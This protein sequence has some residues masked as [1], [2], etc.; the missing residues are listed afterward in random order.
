MREAV[1]R[2]TLRH[3]LARRLRAACVALGIG[4]ALAAPLA[5][6]SPALAQTKFPTAEEAAAALAKAAGAHD[7]AALRAILGP[8]SDRVVSSGDPVADRSAGDRFAQ[9]YAAKNSLAA[10][11]NGSKILTVGENDWPLPI[12]LVQAAGGWQFDISTAEDEI[13][14]R[15][16]GRN[17]LWTIRTLLAGVLA[18]KD[19]FD[20]AQRGTGTG[21]YAQRI[22]STPG[23]LDGLYWET[24]PGEAPSPLTPLV[25]Q[26]MDEGYPGAIA[27]NGQPVPYHGYFFRVLKAQG[28]HAPG[29][30]KDYVRKGEMTEGFA[31]L[32]WPARYDSSGV[33]S[34]LVGPDG[35]VYQ[36]DLGPGTARAAAGIT[37][38]DPDLSWV[39]VKLAD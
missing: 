28:P 20:R 24:D 9:A 14:D 26:A 27:P 33:V 12:P 10:G 22:L 37:R 32:A 18:E 23:K 4:L 19:Y 30:A 6:A 8:Q 5:G 16:I 21:F 36:K 34:F 15:R 31:F 7:I 38:F 11:P 29:G 17:E 25:Q 13:V 3:S 1:M 2:N 35:I 39:P